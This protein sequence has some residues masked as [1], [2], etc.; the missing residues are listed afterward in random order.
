[1]YIPVLKIFVQIYI[2][3]HESIYVEKKR[4]FKQTLNWLDRMNDCGRT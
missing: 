1:M 3:L 2:V 4:N